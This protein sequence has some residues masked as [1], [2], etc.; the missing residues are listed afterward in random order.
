MITTNRSRSKLKLCLFHLTPRG[1]A[2][3]LY[4]LFPGSLSDSPTGVVGDGVKLWDALPPSDV[5][6]VGEG[7]DSTAVPPGQEWSV[8]GD[9]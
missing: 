5:R 7:V 3:F 1:K 2:G 6:G 4:P 8:A 9:N